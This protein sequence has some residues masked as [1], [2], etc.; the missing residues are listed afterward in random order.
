MQNVIF[1]ASPALLRRIDGLAEARK[2]SRTAVLR[3]AILEATVDEHAAA[4]ADLDEILVLLTDAARSGSVPA[5]KT[6]LAHHLRFP[7]P[8]AVDHSILGELDELAA[9][10]DPA[11]RGTARLA[12]AIA[13]RELAEVVAE[14]VRPPVGVGG[15]RLVA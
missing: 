7:R 10:R 11:R 12:V 1:R 14:E 3:A 8:A 5:M 15:R 6:L 9:R 13:A 2:L 4:V